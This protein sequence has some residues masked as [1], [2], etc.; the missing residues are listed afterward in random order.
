MR[1]AVLSE[2]QRFEVREVPDPEPGPGRI[3]VRVTACGIC[4]SDLHMVEQGIVPPDAV[5]GHEF[6]GVVEAVG[7]GASGVAAGD[8]VAVRPFEPCG[9]C[10][11]CVSGNEGRCEG[12]LATTHGL[13]LR[14]GAY[15]E[16]VEAAPSQLFRLPDTFPVELGA[17][18]EPLAVALRGLGRAGV[19]EGTT[20]GVVGCGP[21]GLCAV[22][23]AQALGAG[24]VWACDTNA[25]RAGLAQEAGA[26]A[27]GR[28]PQG[29]AEVVVE[30]AGARGTL[31]T[32]VGAA[33]AGGTVVVLAA[34]MKGDEV[35]PAVWVAREVT[36]LPSI[37][38]TPDEYDEAG[39]LIATERVDVAPLVTSRVPLD[40]LDG[41]FHE[42]L[43]GADEGKVLVTP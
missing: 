35:V 12:A 33:E 40:A 13:G 22:L 34:N 32:A 18:A 38:Y 41:A 36:V 27:T 10:G 6:S 24:P 23:A 3:T 25:F 28:S 5:L 15:A 16:L 2:Q 37:G 29:M 19:S 4:G 20:V 43:E 14:P 8:P 7:E 1:A 9:D 42:L 17:L 26:D 30:C 39:R 11:P 31:D 21:I